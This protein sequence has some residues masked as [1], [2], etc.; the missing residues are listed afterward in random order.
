M[1]NSV[2]FLDLVRE[3][4]SRYNVS[5]T[6][7]VVQENDGRWWFLLRPEGC[8]L[9]D[10]EALRASDKVEIL[11]LEWSN[12]DEAWYHPELVVDPEVY[13]LDDDEKTVL[14]WFA[15]DGGADWL[16]DAES[17]SEA[18]IT[19]KFVPNWD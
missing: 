19:S 17:I 8:F 15:E 1:N 10:A 9:R 5:L 3:V 14:D 13:D 12:A 11:G 16:L 2:K 18:L 6:T 7:S 4:A